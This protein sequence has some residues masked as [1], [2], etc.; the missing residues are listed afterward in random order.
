MEYQARGEKK[1]RDRRKET[2]DA[3]FSSYVQFS[4]CQLATLRSVLYVNFT[5]F[6]SSIDCVVSKKKRRITKYLQMEDRYFV[7]DHSL[8]QQ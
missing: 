5:Y 8:V 3:I 4:L 2:R 1:T 6:T 7:L